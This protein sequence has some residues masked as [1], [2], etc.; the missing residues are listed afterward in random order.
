MRFRL[1]EPF[2]DISRERVSNLSAECDSNASALQAALESN[3][4]LQ[5]DLDVA[6]HEK[7]AAEA[8]K[9]AAHDHF[10]I[11][12]ALPDMIVQSATDL[13]AEVTKI[14]SSVDSLSS[15]ANS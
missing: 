4:Q 10:K 6:I 8:I 13:A 15:D 12:R 2:L 7:T 1:Q 3:A 14:V 9:A 11:L 5:R